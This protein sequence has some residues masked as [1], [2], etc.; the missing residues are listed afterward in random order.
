MVLC[1]LLSPK[2]TEV[3]RTY[4]ICIIYLVSERKKKGVKKFTRGNIL[5]IRTKIF[6]IM[7]W[8][9]LFFFGG[10]G[11]GYSFFFFLNKGNF[12]LL[13]NQKNI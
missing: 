9:A 1:E 3:S 6:N 7:I 4:N 12:G 11:G 8:Q 2:S 5:D 13:Y 10:G